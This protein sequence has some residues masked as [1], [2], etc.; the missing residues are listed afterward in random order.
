MRI[1]CIVFL[2]FFL[3]TLSF[4]QTTI[5]HDKEKGIITVH[6]KNDTTDTTFTMPALEV[7][8]EGTYKDSILVNYAGV[9]SL[10][11]EK[12]NF[13]PCGNWIPDSLGG[14]PYLPNSMGMPRKLWNQKFKNSKYLSDRPK[15]SSG[16]FLSGEGWLVGPS[17]YDHFGVNRYRI[18]TTKFKEIRWG[19]PK[20]CEE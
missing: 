7:T 1:F 20:E 4:A 13:V 17:H 19:M 12:N 2:S 15:K 16:I 11:F 8:L 3:A 5:E 9:W 14:A 6:F 10:G 18:K